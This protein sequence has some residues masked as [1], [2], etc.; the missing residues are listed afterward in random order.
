MNIFPYT[1]NENIHTKIK[2]K[3]P[4]MLAQNRYLGVNVYHI[5]KTTKQ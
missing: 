3:I 4:P 1:N 5:L 2:F